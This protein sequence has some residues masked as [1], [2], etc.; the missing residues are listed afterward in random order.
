MGA[1]G[2]RSVLVGCLCLVFASLVWCMPALAATAPV[3]EDESVSGVA[4]TIATLHARINPGE[5]ETSYRFEYGPTASY[6]TTVPV[7]DAKILAGSASVNVTAFLEGLQA[8]VTYHYRV[9]ASNAEGSAHGEDHILRTYSE[10]SSAPDSCS[11]AIIR[12]AQFSSYL[13]DCRAYELVSPMDKKGANIAADG[14]TAQSAV[15]GNAIKYYS[16]TAFGDAVGISTRGAEYVSQRGEE[17]WSTHAINPEQGSTAFSLFAP[18]E[19]QAL[20]PDL[21]KGIYYARTPV[22]PGHPN[23]EHVSNLY[24]RTD[25]LSP[26]AGSY[27]LLSDSVNPLPKELSSQG[28]FISFA[29]ASADWKHIFFESVNNLTQD[30]P[31]QPEACTVE[32]TEAGGGCE[33]RIYE[34]FDG[35]V[36]LVSVLPNGEATNAVIGAGAGG[37]ETQFK[38]TFTQEA[39]SS[40]GSRVLFE[41]GPF[42]V[43]LGSFGGGPTSGSALYMRIAGKETIKLNVR[44]RTEADPNG[45]QPVTFETAT[46]DDSKVFFTTAEALTDDAPVN[47]GSTKLYMYDVNAPAGK[48]LN[49]ISVD[50]EPSDDLSG[51]NVGG[52]VDGISPNGEYVYFET[53]Q[54]LTPDQPDFVSP[55]GEDIGASAHRALFVWHNG[56]LRYIT[57]HALSN[58]PSGGDTWGSDGGKSV[59][60]NFRVSADG[61]TIVFASQDPT[62][63]EQVGY[64]NPYNAKGEYAQKY[65]AEIYVYK[66]DT[67]KLTCASCNPSGSLPQSMAGFTANGYVDGISAYTATELEYTNYKTRALTEDGRY[68][69]FDTG[70]ALLPQ[71]TNGQRDVYQYDTETGQLHLISGGACNCVSTFI[72][73]TPDGSDVFFVT[74]QDLVRTDNDTNSDVYD[75]RLNGG[76]MS[77]NVAPPAPCESDDCQGPA[78]APP[79]FSLPTSST[80]AGAG[81]QSPPAG[82]PAVKAKGTHARKHRK[83]HKRKHR[84]KRGK[85]N[86]GASHRH[87]SSPTAR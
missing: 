61:K 14:D 41:T 38:G 47:P 71:D 84:K 57:R 73:A 75:A 64:D 52:A 86:A 21:T 25:L 65:S 12:S 43:Y 20:S 72:D 70:D 8:G 59:P 46:A 16:T 74:S 58:F 68:V 51:G 49:L 81:N 85:A 13:P 17:G 40:D 4:Y 9:V 78:K 11:N 63:A 37:N 77:Q 87:T 6:G 79:A 29:G 60:P 62:T 36:R 55:Y 24:L 18:A 76:I 33:P 7:P 27:Q 44:E 80:F 67:G 22:E 28:Q 32:R 48:H 82:K 1:R 26:G 42:S 69:F 15:N 3:I 2:L 83:K 19:Y 66:Y 31:A 45:P 5:A 50:S 10:P 30:A 56:V 35:A 39:V 23:V 54:L 53:E 34:W